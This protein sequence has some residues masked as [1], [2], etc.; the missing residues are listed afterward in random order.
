MSQFCNLVILSGAK[1]LTVNMLLQA[2]SL[3]QVKGLDPKIK[4]E[5][6]K[7]KPGLFEKQKK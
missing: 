2:E 5:L 6:R 4:K 3:Y 1:N 7:R